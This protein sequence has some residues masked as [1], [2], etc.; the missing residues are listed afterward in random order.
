VVVVLAI[1]GILVGLL[2][3]AI[4]SVRQAVGR[5]RCANN[6]RQVGLAFCHYHD[7]VEMFPASYQ[8][9][10]GGG[11][12]MGQPAASGDAG[13]GWGFLMQLL[14]YAEQRP[15]HNALNA[16]LPCWDA[17]NTTGTQLSISTYLCPAAPTML[18]TYPVVDA[19]GGPLATFARASYVANAGRR[20]VWSNPAADLSKIADGPLY[21]NS[22]TNAYGV[23][24]G[25]SNTVFVGEHS[26]SLSD[27]TWVGVVPGAATCPLPRFA[28][29]PTCG[30]AA[31]QVNFRS[32]PNPGE[33][34]PLVLL[35]SRA[36]G[37]VD[38]V[39]SDHPGGSN[40]LLGD[41]SVRFFVSTLAP[42]VWSAMC[43]RSGA[44]MVSSDDY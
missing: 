6:L 31:P 10:P 3:P 29:G 34:P 23:D 16:E 27:A 24:D 18:A 40:I 17:A 19:L 25:L 41:G 9:L 2:L 12:V 11:G 44:E 22:L 39:W 37:H 36:A 26:A 33:R 13:L 1:I 32:G 21:R 7:V 43:T 28:A 5:T 8:V 15:V 4:A 42:A 20:D 38:Q 14:P 30:P 35:P